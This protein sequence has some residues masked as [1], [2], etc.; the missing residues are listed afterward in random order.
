M[1]FKMDLEAHLEARKTHMANCE[2]FKEH[3]KT[4]ER[5]TVNWKRDLEEAPFEAF[6]VMGSSGVLIATILYLSGYMTAAK[7]FAVISVGLFGM[8]M[9]A[10][11]VRKKI[12]SDLAGGDSLGVKRPGQDAAL[13]SNSTAG[14]WKAD[15]QF[16]YS[17]LLI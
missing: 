8:G 13:G 16:K 4:C 14:D 15:K 12:L 11:I 9:A 3:L 5:D 2:L 10:C 6:F 1:W 7:R 17:S